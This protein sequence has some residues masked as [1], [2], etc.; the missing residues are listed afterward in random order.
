MTRWFLIAGVSGAL[1]VVVRFPRILELLTTPAPGTV[2]PAIGALAL[3]AAAFAGWHWSRRGHSSTQDVWGRL[4]ASKSFLI[5]AGVVAA[6]GLAALLAPVLTS[7]DP[8]AQ[9]DILGAATLQPSWAHPF[10]TDMV[11]SAVATGTT[12]P[13]R[14]MWW[15]VQWLGL[16]RPLPVRS[17]RAW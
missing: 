15:G 1:L 6:L 14:P 11:G 17:P 5:G 7:Y 10:G 2:L 3:P 13:E 9:P 12:K 8:N 4:V 16:P